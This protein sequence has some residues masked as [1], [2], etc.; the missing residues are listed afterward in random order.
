MCSEIKNIVFDVGR[1]L[2]DYHPLE[3]CLKAVEDP[4]AAKAVYENLFC[5][6]EW[7]QCDSGIMTEAE[8]VA[9]VQKRIPQYAQYVAL[10]MTDWPDSM[11]AMP[12]ME[13]LVCN[14]KDKRYGLYLLSNTSPRFYEFS[15]DYPV[16][17]YFDGKII[18]CTEKLMKPDPAIYRLLCSRFHLLPEECLFIDDMQ[19]NVDSARNIGMAAHRFQGADELSTYFRNVGIC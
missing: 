4:K 16:F 7:V 17:R 1:V 12:G 8:C 5:G 3:Y 18:S 9:S 2:L 10:V 13:Q 15:K 6:N 11:S 14:L 19:V